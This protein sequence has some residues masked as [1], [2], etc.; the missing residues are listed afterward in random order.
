MDKLNP[1]DLPSLDQ[2]EEMY[3]TITCKFLEDIHD[4]SLENIIKAQRTRD[5]HLATYFAT[6]GWTRF[7]FEEELMRRQFIAE[8]EEKAKG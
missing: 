1:I 5:A 6:S 3:T 4:P 8:R 7:A 2:I